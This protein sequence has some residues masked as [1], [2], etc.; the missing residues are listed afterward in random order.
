MDTNRPNCLLAFF[1]F[2]SQMFF[3]IR[4]LL[5]T[6]FP[7]LTDLMLLTLNP[8]FFPKLLSI[9]ILAD[10]FCPNL[11]SSPTKISLGL[12]T[13][14]RCFLAKAS[15]LNLENLFVK[16]ITIQTSAPN[17]SMSFILYSKDVNVG[18]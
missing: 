13:L 6:F 2:P 5:M 1:N 10:L 14:E 8:Y 12:I 4:V 3:R 16:G 11:K 9:S 18:R 17:S 15:G 7:L